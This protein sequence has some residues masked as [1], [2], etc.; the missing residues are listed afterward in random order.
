[1]VDP[2]HDV[3][4]VKRNTLINSLAQ[5]QLS[6]QS[7]GLGFDAFITSAGTPKLFLQRRHSQTNFTDDHK[8]A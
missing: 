5:P 7:K 4:E 2:F 8:K 3:A 6:S 1:M